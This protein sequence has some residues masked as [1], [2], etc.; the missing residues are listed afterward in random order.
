[1]AETFRSIRQ[2]NLL[3]PFASDVRHALRLLARSPIFTVTAVLSLALGVAGS[4]AVFSLA[5]ALFLRPRVGVTDPRT[6]VD[7]GRTTNGDGFDNF[8]YPLFAAMRDRTVLPR[9]FI[10]KGTAPPGAHSCD[11]AMQSARR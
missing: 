9:D 8:G 10:S 1:M 11:A 3:M 5:D 4:A 7:I 2:S 6:L